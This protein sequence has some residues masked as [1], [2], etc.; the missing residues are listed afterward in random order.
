VKAPAFGWLREAADAA[1]CMSL[2][3]S[4]ASTINDAPFDSAAYVRMQRIV[5]TLYAEQ[6]KQLHRYDRAADQ[7]KKGR[8]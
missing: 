4:A 8:P 1:A 5:K 2:L 7:V 3:D 6:R